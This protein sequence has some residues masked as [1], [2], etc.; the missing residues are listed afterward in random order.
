MTACEQHKAFFPRQAS[1]NHPIR[2]S[3]RIIV[4]TINEGRTGKNSN[5]V[6]LK[7]KGLSS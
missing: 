5:T 2:R 1:K 4:T 6:S 7:E 3:I